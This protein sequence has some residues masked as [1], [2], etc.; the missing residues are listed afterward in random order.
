MK[1]NTYCKYYL[2]LLAFLI[3]SSLYAQSK[4]LQKTYS[5]KYSVS[6][7]VNLSFNNYDCDLNIQTWDKPTIEYKLQVTVT[8]LKPEDSEILNNYLEN[9][10]FHTSANRVTID[11]RFWNERNTRNN[12]TKL[13]LRNGEKIT[14]TKFQISGELKVPTGTNLILDSKYSNIEMDDIYGKLNLKL[15]NDKLYAGNV[16]SNLSLEAKYSTIEFENIK[17]ITADLYNTDMEAKDMGNLKIDSKYSKIF[18][19]EVQNVDLN[20]YND[21]LVFESTENV[22]FD[23]KYSSFIAKKSKMLKVDTYNCTMVIDEIEN[24]EIDSK[25]S[26]F[27]FKNGG[28]CTLSSSF[29]DGVK[30]LNLNKLK[31][32]ESKYGTYKI[33]ELT[34]KLE[35]TDGYSDKFE[36]IKTS[37]NLKGIKVNEKYGKI[38]IGI[39]EQLDFHLKARIKYPK[40]NIDDAG[41]TTKIKILE[42]SDLEYEGIKGTE[43]EN[44][45]LIRITGYNVSLTINEY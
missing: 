45:P 29:N 43:I 34:D 21:K 13:E 28:N 3:S 15:Y 25:Y 35:V 33:E 37:M 41:V 32:Y 4:T 5:W 39:P 9:L 11:N 8:G 6:A 16:G 10:S 12:K 31:I 26:K 20:S 19:N 2:V 23:A 17:D 1:T 44:M 7:D 18:C 38:R 14:L 40:L 42:N 24:I 36:I 27:E 30:Y 22:S